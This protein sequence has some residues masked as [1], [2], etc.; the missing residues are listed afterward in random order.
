[1]G[2]P[3]PVRHGE[4]TPARGRAPDFWQEPFRELENLWERM[5]QVFDPGWATATGLMMP[6]AGGWQPMVDIEETEDSYLFEADL[7]GVR[8]E[9]IKVELRDHELWITGELKQKERTGIVRRQTRRTGTFSYRTTLP[10]EID[11]DNV[12][13]RFDN[14]VLTVRVRK[15]E[16]AKPRKIEIQ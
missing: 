11:P 14:G 12:E 13:A 10:A 16:K 6:R 4:Q 3:V 7:P 15:A 8:R 1:M 9:D 2:E 5:G